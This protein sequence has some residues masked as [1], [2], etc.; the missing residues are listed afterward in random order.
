M[1]KRPPLQLS[2]D[3]VDAPERRVLSLEPDGILCMPVIG[4]DCFRRKWEQAPMHVHDECLEVSLCLRGDLEFETSSGTRPFRP[5]SIF[6]SGPT[7]SAFARK[8][9]LF[10]YP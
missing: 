3:Y 1:S 4:F 5:G 7:R 9:G 6:V 8:Y 10:Q 2:F